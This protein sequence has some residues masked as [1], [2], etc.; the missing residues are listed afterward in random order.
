VSEP[1]LRASDA[2]REQTAQRL[3]HAASEGRLTVDELEERLGAAY[4]GVTRSELAALLA[5]VP[6]AALSPVPTGSSVPVRPGGEG[7][8]RVLN[9]LGGSD[10]KGHWRLAP[11]VTMVNLMGGGD[12]DLND[13]E[14]AAET[15]E[16]RIWSLMGGG[17]VYV[18]EGL[19]V[20]ISEFAFMG[21]NS[22]DLGEG[23]PD[24]GGPRLRLRLISIMGGADVRRGRKK[25]RAE[26][27]RERELKRSA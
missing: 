14:F 11:R 26:R 5:D 20:E 15:V 25:S 24:P 27:R 10:R 21:G 4:A 2:E 6:D 17:D 7:T 13:A 19:D 22:I 8:R 18:P 12:L 9:I 23:R 3:R 1:D 16:L